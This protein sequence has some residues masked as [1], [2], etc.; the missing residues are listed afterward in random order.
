MLR[1]ET[2]ERKVLKKSKEEINEKSNV[3]MSHKNENQS[4][5]NFD[6]IYAPFCQAIIVRIYNLY[7]S[8]FYGC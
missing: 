3:H 1:F 5:N 6:F 4:F 2:F 7:N 8:I